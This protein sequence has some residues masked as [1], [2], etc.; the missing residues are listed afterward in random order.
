[1]KTKIANN[2]RTKTMTK[3]IELNIKV[4]E[5]YIRLIMPNSSEEEALRII[6]KILEAKEYTIPTIRK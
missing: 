5:E 1:M 4:D 6:K 3:D 2:E